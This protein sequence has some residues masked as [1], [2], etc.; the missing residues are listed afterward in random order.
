MSETELTR[1]VAET[2]RASGNPDIVAVA[3]FGGEMDTPG[4]R[5]AHAGGGTTYLVLTPP[6][7]SETTA[8]VV[9]FLDFVAGLLH[10]AQRPEILRVETVLTAMDHPSGL[11]V[12]TAAG[13]VRVLRVLRTEARPV[14]AIPMTLATSAPD[15]SA[16]RDAFPRA[17]RT[18]SEGGD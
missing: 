3:P 15:A 18:E 16:I 7:R 14:I 6:G 1:L 17:G 9:K 5:I 12:T 8:D 13:D 2:I 10:R 4:I 11:R